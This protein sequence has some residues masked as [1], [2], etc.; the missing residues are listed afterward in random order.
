MP[1]NR[2]LTN[3][4]WSIICTI[5]QEPKYRFLQEELAQAK[6]LEARGL[7]QSIGNKCFSV[8]KLGEEIY[9]EVNG[10]TS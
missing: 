8:T 5:H 2:T 10:K 9:G 6:K 4:E 1:K 3:D 7:I